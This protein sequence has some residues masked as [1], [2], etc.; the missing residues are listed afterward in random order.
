MSECKD[1]SAKLQTTITETSDKLKQSEL[2]VSEVKKQLEASMNK[3]CMYVSL[4]L[5]TETVKS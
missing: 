5:K 2:K 3:V 4:C 1:Q